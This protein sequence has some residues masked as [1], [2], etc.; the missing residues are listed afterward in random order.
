M[1]SNAD[2]LDSGPGVFR[3]YSLL[4]PAAGGQLPVAR[5]AQR[6]DFSRN[7]QSWPRGPGVTGRASKYEGI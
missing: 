3:R 4:I 7:S 6:C 5:D 1:R 2:T